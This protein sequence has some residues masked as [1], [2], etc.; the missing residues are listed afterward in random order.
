MKLHYKRT[1]VRFPIFTLVFIL[2]LSFVALSY[3]DSLSVNFES[4]TY[5]TG[6]VN[7]QD[8]WSST[9]AYDQA[10]V[11]NTYGYAS[12]GGQSFR[13]SDAFTSGTFGDQTFS[14]S[15]INECGE[16][17]AE[18]GGESGGVRQRHCE[19]SFDLASTLSTIQPG[20][21]LSVSPDRGDGARMSYLRFEDQ[22]DGIHVFFDDVTDPGHVV[23]VDTFS[24]TD[25]ATINRNPHNIKF[26]MDFVDG[27]DN[28]VVK[29]YIDG[30]LKITGTSWE[31]YYAFDTE[32]DPTLN[33]NSRTV[34][35]LLFREAGTANPAHFGNGFLIDNAS[36][37]S[38][39]PPTSIDQCKNGGWQNYTRTNAST[40]K[41]QG[42]CIQYV[43]TGK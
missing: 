40:F 23:N 22:F 7:G 19:F 11:T 2:A 30:V 39:R 38:S 24:D 31:D 32:S 20:M 4:P 41:N 27:P 9:G 12:F 26:V 5:H 10:V 43:N 33:G 37:A 25:I 35:S 1:N 13:I 8:G 34:D 15:L 6:S 21:H 14:K 36:S 18:N 42:D 29:I 3:A 17:N 28:D 16:T